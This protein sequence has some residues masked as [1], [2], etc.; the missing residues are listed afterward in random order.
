MHYNNHSGAYIAGT[1]NSTGAYIVIM[2]SLQALVN[3]L[4]VWKSSCE[5]KL[6]PLK[7]LQMLVD[8]QLIIRTSIRSWRVNMSDARAPVHETKT[9]LHFS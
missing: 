3:C 6:R 9:S 2:A 5:N 1:R 7:Q 4:L 8:I